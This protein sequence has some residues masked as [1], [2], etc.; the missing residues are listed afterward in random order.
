MGK[1]VHFDQVVTHWDE[2]RHVRF[3]YRFDADSFPPG[4]LDDHVRIG[5][6]YFD[7]TDTAYTLSP[8]TETSTRLEIRN[9]L[10]A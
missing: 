1:Q 7:L 5:G 4:A 6:H 9:L 3:A 2:N 8:Q 10:S